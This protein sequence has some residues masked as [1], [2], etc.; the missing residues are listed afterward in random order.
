MAPT[1][2]FGQWVPDANYREHRT[3]LNFHPL[4]QV[5]S[6]NMTQGAESFFALIAIACRAA[7]LGT[8]LLTKV[9]GRLSARTGKAVL[10][11]WLKLAMSRPD[12]AVRR[13]SSWGAR[14]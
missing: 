11:R 7:L 4:A 5:E 6:G 3:S 9:L 1:A 12:P 10:A 13:Y 14:S 2:E 8:I